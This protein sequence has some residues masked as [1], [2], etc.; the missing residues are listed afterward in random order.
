MITPTGIGQYRRCC[1]FV[2]C[3]LGA[4]LTPGD[5]IS[6]IVRAVALWGMFELGLVVMR[7]SYR[8]PDEP[9]DPA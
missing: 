8:K 1:I 2:G 6:M 7:V 4:L 5:P 3:I 9:T